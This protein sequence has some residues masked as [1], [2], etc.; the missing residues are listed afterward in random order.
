MIEVPLQHLPNQELI[1]ILDGQNVTLHVYQRGEDESTRMFLDVSVGST[2]VQRGAPML[3]RVG[4]LSTPKDFTGQFRLVDSAAKPDWQT[5][6]VY[7]QIGTAVNKDR[8]RLYYLSASEDAAVEAAYKE[9]CDAAAM[10]SLSTGSAV[11]SDS[12]I[13]GEDDA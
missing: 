4:I 2:V 12:P 8:Y 6:P 13:T 5:T 11:V 7:T 1:M 10:A 3:P 9:R